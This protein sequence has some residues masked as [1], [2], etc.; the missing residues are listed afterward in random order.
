MKFPYRAFRRHLVLVGDD[1]QRRP[2]IPA[3]VVGLGGE[4]MIL[5]LLDTGAEMTLLDLS[6]IDLLDV[7]IKRGDKKS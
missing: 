1:L 7:H 6:F 4:A 5:G 2:N 3:R